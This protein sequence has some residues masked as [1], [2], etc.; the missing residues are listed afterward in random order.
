MTH[1]TVQFE[2]ILSQRLY[3]TMADRDAAGL[4]YTTPEHITTLRQE[5]EAKAILGGTEATEACFKYVFMCLLLRWLYSRE[6]F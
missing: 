1:G 3:A 6:A 2:F 4:P 5:Y